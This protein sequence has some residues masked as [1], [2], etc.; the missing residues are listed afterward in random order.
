MQDYISVMLLADKKYRPSLTDVNYMYGKW[1]LHKKGAPMG[2]ACLKLL[3][4]P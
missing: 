4:Q 2:R 1:Q 3:Q